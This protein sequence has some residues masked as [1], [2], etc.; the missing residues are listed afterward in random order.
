MGNRRRSRELALKVLFHLQFSHDEPR[1]AFDLISENFGAPEDIGPFSWELISGTCSCIDEIDDY[2]SK[3]SKGWRLE[4]MA[5]V[6]RA[7]LRLSVYQLLYREDIPPKVSIN[8]AVELAKKFGNQ[9]SGAFING[10]LDNIYNRVRL[11]NT[12]SKQT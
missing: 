2:I 8:E 10:I 5:R 12:E 9:E 6:E 1:K 4:R 11:K 7:I 3:A